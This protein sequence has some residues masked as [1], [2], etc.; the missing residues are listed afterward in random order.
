MACVFGRSEPSWDMRITCKSKDTKM[1]VYDSLMDQLVI[2]RRDGVITKA[3]LVTQQTFWLKEKVFE[4]EW[5][6]DEELQREEWVG[7][8]EPRETDNPT[9]HCMDIFVIAT[10]ES[11]PANPQ[12]F[13]Q[14]KM[15]QVKCWLSEKVRA[16]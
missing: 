1:V 10:T 11:E 6:Y 8:E 7:S 16:V 14:R 3:A 9:G 4:G 2:L 15:Q 12:Q 13:W 5:I